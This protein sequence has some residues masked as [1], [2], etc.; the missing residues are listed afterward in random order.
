MHAAD[1]EDEL[2][3]LDQFIE[4]A[5]KNRFLNNA[6]VSEPGFSELYVRVGKRSFPETNWCLQDV[7]EIGRVTAAHPGR[8]CFTRLAERLLAQGHVLFVECVLN[9]RFSRK[10]RELGF[11]QARNEGAPCFYKFPEGRWYEQ[12]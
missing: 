11:T 8:G 5:R 10:L 6:F 7:L 4:R 1:L 9:P 2:P 12:C 3:T